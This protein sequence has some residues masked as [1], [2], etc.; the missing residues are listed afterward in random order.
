MTENENNAN[1]LESIIK[2]EKEEF[3]KILIDDVLRSE[4]KM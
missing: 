2:V 3:Q 1:T 4:A